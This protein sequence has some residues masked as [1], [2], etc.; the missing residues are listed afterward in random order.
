M[1]STIA[2][3][4]WAMLIRGI[5]ALIFGILCFFYP[6]SA[7]IVLVMFF[8]AY[9]LVDGI[10]AIAAAIGGATDGPPWWML[11]LEGIFGIIVGV[12][13]FFMPGVTALTLVYL[14]A[15]W[16]I[17]TG[18]LQVISAIRLRKEISGEWLLILG[19]VISVIFGVLIALFPGAGALTIVIWIGVY[20]VLMG[21]LFI[22]LGLRLRSLKNRM[23]AE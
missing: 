2:R 10:F 9:A 5:L 16:A 3:N 14:I 21:I 23:A 13:T 1:I 7:L 15:G 8:G 20:A 6:M 22:M 11:L 19:G 18:V 17:V 4:W 12:L